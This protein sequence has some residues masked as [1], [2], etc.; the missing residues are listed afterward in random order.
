[1]Y[2][3]V[4]IGAG[5]A[6]CV[7][8]NRLSESNVNVLLLEAGNRDDNKEIHIPVAFSKLFQTKYDWAYFTEKQPHLNNRSVFFPRGKCLGGSSSINAMIYIRGDWQDYN[9]WE[10]NDNPGWGAQDALKYLKKP[11]IK[12]EAVMTTTL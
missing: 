4:V 10:N 9:Q 7:L 6:G 1:M 3:Y 5:S 12:Q 11:K 2:D 8:A